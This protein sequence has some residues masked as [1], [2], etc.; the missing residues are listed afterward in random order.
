MSKRSKYLSSERTGDGVCV[1]N[2]NVFILGRGEKERI[3]WNGGIGGPAP[4]PAPVLRNPEPE[5]I[6]LVQNCELMMKMVRKH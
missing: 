1:E 6:R 5:K 3:W 2:D 4:E